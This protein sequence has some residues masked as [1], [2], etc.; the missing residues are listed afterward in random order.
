M[1]ANDEETDNNSP[2]ETDGTHDNDKD[3]K[4]E[5]ENSYGS[6][7]DDSENPK[8]ADSKDNDKSSDGGHQMKDGT[9]FGQLDEFLDEDFLSENKH[10]QYDT[11]YAS[12]EVEIFSV[13]VTTTD[14]Y[15]IETDFADDEEYIDFLQLIKEKSEV[16]TEVDVTETDNIITLSTCD[17]LSDPEKGRLVVHGKVRIHD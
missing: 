15:Y 9:M 4:D 8:N 13:Y 14:F 5:N 7:S 3:E 11:I 6:P 10:F 17:N 1:V 12:Y 16:T 2:D